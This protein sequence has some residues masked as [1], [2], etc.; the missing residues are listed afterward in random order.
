MRIRTIIFGVFI[1]LIVLIVGYAF[2]GSVPAPDIYTIYQ[3]QPKVDGLNLPDFESVTRIVISLPNTTTTVIIENETDINFIK[4]FISKYP[5]GWVKY[6]NDKLI[7]LQ[8]QYPNRVR[9]YN[10]SKI[11]KS[12]SIN[13]EMIVYER[14]GQTYWKY[15]EDKEFQAFEARILKR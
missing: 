12:F 4:E 13:T 9:L 14:N 1:G 11:V 8:V 10:D 15:L 2:L 3:Q 6:N 7:L 5:N